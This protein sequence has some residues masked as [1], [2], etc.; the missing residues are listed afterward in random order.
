MLT[1]SF[2]GMVSPVPGELVKIVTEGN[3]TTGYGWVAANTTTLKIVNET[4]VPTP[5][6]D[7]II[8]A[9]EC[10]SGWSPRSTQ[11]R[12]SSVRT[13]SV[14]RKPIPSAPSGLA[15]PSGDHK[16][17][18]FRVMQTVSLVNLLYPSD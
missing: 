5:I 4:Y 7:D 11:V 15:S 6:A 16:N 9:G 12:T 8:G 18:F 10:T 17:I 3:P 13:T 1:V 14:P 2:E